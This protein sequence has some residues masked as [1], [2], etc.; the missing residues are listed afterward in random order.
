MSV[1][2]TDNKALVHDFST[3]IRAATPESIDGL[4]REHYADDVSWYGPDPINDLQGLAAVSEEF[5]TPLLRAFPDLEK[6]D[7]AL[8]AGEFEGAE[9]VCATGNLVG[10]F[11]NEWLD[12]P[13]TGHATWLRYGEFH[14][15]EN[16][17][18]VET[19]LII[20]LL[21][22]L[23][24]AGYQFFPALAP[25]VVIP[26]PTTH[27]G[28]LL[29]D[30][31][32]HESERTLRLVED[33][34][35]NLHVYEERGLYG[36]DLQRYWHEDFMWYGPAGIGT[37][38]GIDGFREFHQGPF[39]EAFPDREGGNHVARFAE[40][41][42]CAST[43]WPSLTA[44]HTGDGWLGLPATDESV[45]MRVMDVWRREG[46]LLAENWVFI[47]MVDLLG[48]LGV[49]VFDRLRADEQYF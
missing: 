42:Y 34:L 21:D 9:W 41:N 20:D 8:F 23:Q 13:A 29:D 2:R 39:L 14:R 40:G 5:W 31:A 17:R 18:I 36:I 11:E 19:R 45:E 6:N 35:E 47:D 16:G 38:R 3:S 12:V 7:Y 37:T 27:D 30:Q 43:G 24:Q 15:L 22:V 1:E 26:G 25:E 46:D 49:D 28:V 4:L 48:Q 33:M 32:A 10:T 44:T